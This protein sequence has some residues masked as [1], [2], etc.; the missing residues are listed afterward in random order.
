[1][2]HKPYRIEI[3]ARTRP[4]GFGYRPAAD[5]ADLPIDEV[6]ARLRTDFGRICESWRSAAG[7]GRVTA[8]LKAVLADTERAA[9]SVLG[10][11]EAL[12]AS[13]ASLAAAE[14]DAIRVLRDRIGT[15]FEAS[16]FHDV[17]GQR[18]NQ[19][20]TALG[21]FEAD[22]ASLASALGHPLPEAAALPC[23]AGPDLVALADAAGEDAAPV[24]LDGPAVSGEPDH[25]TQ[26]DIDRL[27]D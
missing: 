5:V 21:Q 12:D 14:P 16:S 8:E 3:A 13:A 20:M 4:S 15:I 18:V 27:F 26:D 2:S 17:T 6:A 23:A 25:V 9:T 7:M 22:L 1:M 10:A 24:A 19:I 11:A